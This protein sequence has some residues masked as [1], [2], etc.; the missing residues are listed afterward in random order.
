MVCSISFYYNG[1]AYRITCI[2][3]L[4]IGQY[5]RLTC[6]L[7]RCK[8]CELEYP[9][10]EHKA[11]GLWPWPP[12]PHDPDYMQCKNGRRIKRGKCPTDPLWEVASFPYKGQCVHLFAVPKDYNPHGE[13]PSCLG[14]VDGNYQFLVGYCAGYYK[15]QSGVATA[16]KCPYNT[17]FDTASRT[18]KIGGKC[19]Y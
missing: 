6:K 3:N 15:C 17:L 5:F 4:Q 13:L 9:S 2:Y 16:V 18:C 8:P 7:G 14:K 11:N 12:Y 19:I 10:C 1:I